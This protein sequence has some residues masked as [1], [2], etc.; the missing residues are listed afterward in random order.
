MRGLWFFFFGNLIVLFP[1]YVSV[2]CIFDGKRKKLYFAFC[3]FGITV[4]G[5]Y[6][7]CDGL[8][9][10][11]HFSEKTAFMFDLGKFISERKKIVKIDGITSL[12]IRTMTKIGK[13]NAAV[14]AVYPLF[15]ILTVISAILSES[16]PALKSR[17]DFGI[18]RSDELTV[19][20]KYSFV[21]NFLSLNLMLLNSIFKKVV[22]GFGRKK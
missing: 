6:V 22:K 3:F 16:K 4:L 2:Y 9:F 13:E 15:P 18:C 21:L 19:F 8:K 1:L 20:I 11:I 14:G 12:E 7:T 17:N 5:G 10:F